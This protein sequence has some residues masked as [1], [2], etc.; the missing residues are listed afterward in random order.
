VGDTKTK[1]D[2]RPLL[3]ET[4][5][6]GV[7]LSALHYIQRLV[8]MRLRQ[9]DLRT[10]TAILPEVIVLSKEVHSLLSP[11]EVPSFDSSSFH[12]YL[13]HFP[14]IVNMQ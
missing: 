13:F 8:P 12:Y 6:L 10:L 9:S 2:S 1:R 7:A 5:Y 4:W 14:V 11:Q 3:K